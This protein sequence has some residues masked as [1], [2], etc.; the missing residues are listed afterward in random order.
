MNGSLFFGLSLTRCFVPLYLEQQ[1]QN[2]GLVTP[3]PVNTF[4]HIEYSYQKGHILGSAN[5]AQWFTI[6]STALYCW[7]IILLSMMIDKEFLILLVVQQLVK[8]P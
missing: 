4:I 5:M 2:V 8:L 3:W 7:Y 1:S 6:G